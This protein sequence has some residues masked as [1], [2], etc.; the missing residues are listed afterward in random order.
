M[1]ARASAGVYQTFL[2]EKDMDAERMEELDEELKNQGLTEIEPERLVLEK[3]G[4][5]IPVWVSAPNDAE[6]VVIIV[7]G[8]G[9]SKE[10]VSSEFY[11]KYFNSRRLAVVVYDQPGHGTAEAS[12][13]PLRVEGALESLAAVEKF[14][15]ERF[16][17]LP[18]VYF[19]SSFGAY[20]TG[21]YVRTRE[22][23]GHKAFMRSGAMIF[24]EIIL[25]RLEVT[26]SKASAETDP[27]RDIASAGR[28]PSGSTAGSLS[29]AKG[30]CDASDTKAAKDPHHAGAVYRDNKAFC[31]ASTAPIPDK[32]RAAED[33]YVDVDL[34][35]GDKARFLEEFIGDLRRDDFDLVKLYRAEKPA[36]VEIAFAHGGL[37]PV[38]PLKRIEEFADEFGYELT[39]MPG[40]GH[41]IC[42]DP[43]MPETLGRLA[44][45]YFARGTRS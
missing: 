41:S 20:V 1:K 5:R 12:L 44:V 7:H 26:D 27:A 35:L 28:G 17:D 2:R 8:L 11:R 43:T 32:G 19:G 38:V 29:D 21:L 34:G 16:P 40:E 18:I 36:D 23:L 42:T 15:R 31:D 13:E 33:G 24:P 39:V 4:G 37:D 30:F 6:K 22:H 3:E 25:G 14:T 45:E 10:A 9:A